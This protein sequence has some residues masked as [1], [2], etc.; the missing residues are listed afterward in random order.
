MLD[1]GVVVGEGVIVGVLVSVGV[2]VAVWV[3]LAVGVNGSVVSVVSI[4]AARAALSFTFELAT[5]N[6][7]ELQANKTNDKAENIQA[8]LNFMLANF[9]FIILVNQIP[10]MQIYGTRSI[11][12]CIC[13][14]VNSP[15]WLK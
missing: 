14:V 13:Q 3:G 9:S 6:E 5:W 1:V 4:A 2:G 7:R 15:Q 12:S 10:S 8:S 11:Q